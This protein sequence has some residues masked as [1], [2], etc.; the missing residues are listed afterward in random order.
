MWDVKLGGSEYQ[1]EGSS[2]SQPEDAPGSCD[3]HGCDPMGDPGGC[4]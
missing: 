1:K 4:E 3:L 2:V